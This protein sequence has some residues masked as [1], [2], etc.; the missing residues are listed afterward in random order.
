MAFRVFVSM[1]YSRPMLVESIGYNSGKFESKYQ[2]YFSLGWFTSV[3]W[4]M[5][6]ICFDLLIPLSGM[7]HYWYGLSRWKRTLRYNIVSLPEPTPRMITPMLQIIDFPW[8]TS[9]LAIRISGTNNYTVLTK[10]MICITIVLLFT[11]PIAAIRYGCAI[12]I[13][14]KGCSNTTNEKWQQQ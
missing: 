3:V 6:T 10:G 12:K 2:S 7:Y 8:H 11:E 1:T 5:G 14:W 4:K 13:P 9:R